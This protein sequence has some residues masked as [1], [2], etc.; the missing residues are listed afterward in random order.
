MREAARRYTSKMG[1][2]LKRLHAW[3]AWIVCFLAVSGVVLYAPALRGPTAPIRTALKQGHIAAGVVS[4]LLLLLYAQFLARHAKQLRGK[5]PQ[6]GNLAVV[7]ILLV[8]WSVTGTIL[9]LERSVPAAWT[10]AALLGHD[11]LTWVGVPYAMF[12]SV[13]RS[14]WVRER[15]ARAVDAELEGALDG[16]RSFDRYDGTRRRLVVGGLAAA[17]ALVAGPA[18]YRW[19][20]RL[21]ASGSMATDDIAV[22]APQGRLPDQAPGQELL[23]PLPE[24]DPPIGGGAEGRFRIYTVTPIPRFDPGNWTFTVDGLVER[25]LSFDWPTFAKLA[26]T[27][28][29][30][31]FHCVTGWSVYRATWEGVPLKELLAAAGVAAGAKYVKFYSGDG[32]YTDALSLEQAGM[33]DVMVAA[34]IDGKPLPEDLGGPVRLIVPK[35][36]AYKSVKW[37]QGIELIDREHIGYWQERGYEIDAWVPGERKA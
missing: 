21:G 7:L 16:R 11:L 26:R 13:S 27:A 35:M 34:L 2:K 10:S 18:V 29:V 25:P 36:Y 3:N 23:E 30:S 37:L 17:A 22:V 6:L 14:R 4:V 24:S 28:Q 31:D 32:V 5:R 8:G 19:L 15:R 12:H 9:W 33:E 20:S 1:G